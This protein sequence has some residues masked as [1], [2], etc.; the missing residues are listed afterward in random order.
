MQKLLTQSTD[1]EPVGGGYLLGGSYL[2]FATVS[3]YLKYIIGTFLSFTL[4]AIIFSCNASEHPF[5]KKSVGRHSVSTGTRL[6]HYS[7]EYEDNIQGQPINHLLRK[8]IGVF[9][10]L[11]TP[12]QATHAEI[13]V[14]INNTVYQKKAPRRLVHVDGDTGLTPFIDA[15][16][17]SPEGSIITVRVKPSGNPVLWDKQVIID[18]QRSVVI[19]GEPLPVSTLSDSHEKTY[20]SIQL[21]EQLLSSGPALSCRDCGTIDINNLHVDL[22]RSAPQNI[23]EPIITIQGKP[24][25]PP[26]LK[27]ITLFAGDENTVRN[28]LQVEDGVLWQNIEI[29]TNHDSDPASHNPAKSYHAY[30]PSSAWRLPILAGLSGLLIRPAAAQSFSTTA[31]IFLNG[32]YSAV[33]GFVL[34]HPYASG[35]AIV[36]IGGFYILPYCI[37]YAHDLFIPPKSKRAK[38]TRSY[39]SSRRTT[40]RNLARCSLGT[41]TEETED[42]MELNVGPLFNKAGVKLRPMI[43]PTSEKLDQIGTSQYK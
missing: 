2:F 13:P 41:I 12:D 36:L 5:S 23:S 26:T 3:V 31:G 32:F 21:D 17:K 19:T 8:P 27:N 10:K 24:I 18:G 29:N 28:F 22:T 15:L 33:T 40:P 38:S 25:R 43:G 20:P 37:T 9:D 42:L 16:Q 4:S 39:H 30:K 11:L 34:N 35:T 7:S 14:G 1:P 6:N